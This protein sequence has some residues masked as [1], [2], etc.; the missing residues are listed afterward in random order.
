MKIFY[1]N[2]GG[3]GNWGA[4]AYASYDLLLLA[5]GRVTKQDFGETYNSDTAPPMSIQVKNGSGRIIT[6]PKD[7]D[8]T[9]RE[10]RPMILFKLTTEKVWVVFVHLKSGSAKYATDALATAIKNLTGAFGVSEKD[11]IAWIGD[12]NRADDEML[13]A[14]S[15]F[16]VIQSGGGQAGWNLD[17]VMITGDWSKNGIT[18]SVATTSGDHGHIGISVSI[19]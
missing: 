2:Q 19:A 18:T 1:M 12:F 9:C 16:Q 4:V 17:R 10:V 8:G 11:P 7:L 14:I 13:G 3:G 6:E 5:E 15:G